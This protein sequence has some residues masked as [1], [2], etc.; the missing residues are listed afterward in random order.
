V[1]VTSDQWSSRV[2]LECFNRIGRSP[3]FANDRYWRTN[4]GNGST[5]AD[6]GFNRSTGFPRSRHSRTRQPG[7]RG[8][9]C[10]TS[11]CRRANDLNF[12]LRV[13]QPRKLHAVF[14]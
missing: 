4:Q 3:K 6:R 8:E 1:K 11:Q 5:Q 10:E 13:S 2:S 9:L 14:R 7:N 12:E